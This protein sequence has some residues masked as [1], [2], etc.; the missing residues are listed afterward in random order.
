[1]VLQGI[2]K[3]GQ[4]GVFLLERGFIGTG[5]NERAS[6]RA[7]IGAVALPFVL[8][9]SC[10]HCADG[11]L[12]FGEGHCSESESLSVCLDAYHALTIKRAPCSL[13]FFASND[14]ITAANDTRLLCRSARAFNFLGVP[15]I[16][17][18]ATQG[19]VCLDE[20]YGNNAVASI[21]NKLFDAGGF[22][23]EKLSPAGD[24]EGREGPRRGQFPITGGSVE[25][26]GGSC[27]AL[28]GSRWQCDSS[29]QDGA[30]DTWSGLPC[31]P[32]REGLQRWRKHQGRRP[33]SS[34]GMKLRLS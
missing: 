7:I 9:I 10:H 1:M 4:Q 6:I 13:A 24:K 32:A 23:H 34:G 17:L 16:K 12:R 20:L 28:R 26:T 2:S 21:E 14:E 31:W 22:I 3:S 27:Q 33:G 30:G 5:Q 18:N 8:C 19:A 25:P 11:M 29:A 15:R